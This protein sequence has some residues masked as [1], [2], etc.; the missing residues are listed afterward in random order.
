MIGRGREREGLG[1]RDTE[2]DRER[3]AKDEG[4]KKGDF[5]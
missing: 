2:R 1:W 3:A 4:R 5:G